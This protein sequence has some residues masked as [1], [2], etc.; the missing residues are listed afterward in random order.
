MRVRENKEQP[1]LKEAEAVYIQNTLRSRNHTSMAFWQSQR[2][3]PSPVSCIWLP[4]D[5][6]DQR[7]GLLVKNGAE[8]CFYG[9]DRFAYH[10]IFETEWI[11]KSGT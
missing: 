8:M 7:A 5:K 3:A 1:Q 6:H 11:S 9:W 2:L 4:G 10:P